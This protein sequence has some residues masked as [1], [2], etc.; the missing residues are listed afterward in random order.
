MD[1]VTTERISGSGRV[2]AACKTSFGVEVRV[3]ENKRRLAICEMFRSLFASAEY[4]I[5]QTNKQTLKNENHSK[6]VRNC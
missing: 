1:R 6:N 2:V 4:I 3:D 5:T